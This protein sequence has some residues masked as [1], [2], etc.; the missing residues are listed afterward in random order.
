V[1]GS[2]LSVNMFN[3]VGINRNYKQFESG[4]NLTITIVDSGLKSAFK[5]GILLYH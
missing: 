3:L 1:R 2:A 4:R 5:A